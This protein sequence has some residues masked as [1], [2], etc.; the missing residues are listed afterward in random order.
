MLSAE[1]GITIDAQVEVPGHGKWWLNG[2]TGMDKR[3]CQQ[4]KC[5]INTPEEANSQKKMMSASGL[6]AVES[7][8]Q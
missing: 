4:S 2:K 6:I 1:L 8:S 7:W 5:A 3:Y